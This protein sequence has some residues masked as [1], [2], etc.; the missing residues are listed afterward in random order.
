M[1]GQDRQIAAIAQHWHE[2]K[3]FAR[4]SF[5]MRPINC[6]RVDE[7]IRTEVGSSSSSSSS[8][9]GSSSSSSS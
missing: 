4:R 3:G 9:S 2:K 8:S 5:V 7:L 1:H 6:A